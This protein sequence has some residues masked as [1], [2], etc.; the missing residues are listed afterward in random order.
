MPWFTRYHYLNYYPVVC[1][2]EAFDKTMIHNLPGL[3]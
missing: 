1:N 3:A 2:T